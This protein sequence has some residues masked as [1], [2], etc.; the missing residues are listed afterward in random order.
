VALSTGP[1]TAHT[2]HTAHPVCA[3]RYGRPRRVRQDVREGAAVVAFSA[4]ASTGVAL[5][6]LLLMWLVG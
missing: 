1:H 3:A 5:A 4:A 6:L 2:A